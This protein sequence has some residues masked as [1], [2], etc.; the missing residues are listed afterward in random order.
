MV[1]PELRSLASA[2]LPHAVRAE[3]NAIRQE[4]SALVG[5]N[6]YVFE[7]DLYPRLRALDTQIPGA[8]M[9]YVRWDSGTP[10]FPF[11]KLFD[12][13]VRPVSYVP[14]HLAASTMPLGSMAREVVNDAGAHLEQCVKRVRGAPRKQPLGP[15]VNNPRVRRQIGDELSDAIGKFTRVWNVAKHEFDGGSP[16][17]VLS[18]A[19][20]FEAYF[21]S[22][23]LGSRVLEAA[24]CGTVDKMHT[25]LDEASQRGIFYRRGYLLPMPSHE[26][27]G[28]V[29]TDDV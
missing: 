23:A 17:S 28:S 27:S 14:Y 4:V 8:G 13:V 16:D 29:R 22:R 24:K 18:L 2:W 19:D 26:S 25:A 6:S 9:Q 3:L 21:V 1:G 5:R 12:S 11:S 20:A 15:A 7:R 10:R